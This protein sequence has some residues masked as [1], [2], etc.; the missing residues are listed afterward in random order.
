MHVK[1]K[2]GTTPHRERQEPVGSSP[3]A[4]G[5]PFAIVSVMAEMVC[6]YV[7]LASTL[8]AATSTVEEFRRANRLA[9]Q[10]AILMPEPLYRT[11]I[12]S[13]VS[14]DADHHVLQSV[15]DVRQW[16]MMIPEERRTLT[17]DHLPYH[18]PGIGV[19]ETPEM[20]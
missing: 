1:D 2:R 3:Q 12:T 20:A 16:L 7:A 13:I 10:L 5:M 15:C 6:E 11:M 18:A 4:Q 17:G 8:D 9:W 19:R 14:P